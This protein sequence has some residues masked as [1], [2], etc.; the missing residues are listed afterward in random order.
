[1]RP[2]GRDELID[3]PEPLAGTERPPGLAHALAT[4]TDRWAELTGQYQVWWLFAPG[5]PPQAAF[6]AVELRWDDEA[7]PVRLLSPSDPADPC[8][9][10][11]AWGS[12]DRFYHYEARL[13]LVL[14]HWDNDTASEDADFWRTFR[15]D[16]VRR[17][18]KSIRAY[19]R[20]RLHEWQAD[21]PD[22]P[23]PREAAAPVPP[24]PPPPPRPA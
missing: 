19:L 4:V 6:P 10:A 20:H 22:A 1:H 18:W 21:H 8:S 11:R 5:F 3:F 13:G 2:P 24:D 14:V 16:R 17:Q 15:Q 12:P 23:P 7:E 9:S